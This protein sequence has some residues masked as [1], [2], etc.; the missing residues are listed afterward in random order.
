[1]RTSPPNLKIVLKT[2]AQKPKGAIRGV[3]LDGQHRAGLLGQH[4]R[5]DPVAAPRL[6]DVDEGDPHEDGEAAQGDRVEERPGRHAAEPVTLSQLEDAQDQG[7]EDEGHDDHEDQ[8]QEDLADR[9][10]KAAVE[11]V[12]PADVLVRVK[13]GSEDHPGC[14]RQKKLLVLGHGSLLRAESLVQLEERSQERADA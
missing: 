4:G 2:M 8:A 7:R 10:Q 6:E 3:L 5:V 11:L 9:V 1:V 14:E 12:E 13:D